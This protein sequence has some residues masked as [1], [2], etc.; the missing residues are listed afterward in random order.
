[1]RNM[2]WPES[3]AGVAASRPYSGFHSSFPIPHSSFRA[4]GGYG[5]RGDPASLRR[6]GPRQGDP[7]PMLSEP[8]ESIINVVRARLVH[9]PWRRGR[10]RL[11]RF[12]AGLECPGVESVSGF[13]GIA[14][15]RCGNA[16]ARTGPE[17]FFPTQF[18]AARTFFSTTFLTPPPR[19]GSEHD[20]WHESSWN[21]GVR[22][23][24]SRWHINFLHTGFVL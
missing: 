3:R 18:G 24:P 11:T 23:A 1:M 12:R 10:N 15:E 22:P 19:P 9:D 13:G 8:F 17:D 6:A 16:S 7:F 5:R 4:S 20:A 2:E 21:P 14:T